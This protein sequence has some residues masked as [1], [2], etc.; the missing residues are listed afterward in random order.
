VPRKADLKKALW[1][2]AYER[3]NVDVGLACGLPGH[4]QIG[5]GMWAM[6]D[7][8]AE[9]RAQAERFGA[10]IVRGNVTGVDVST[11]PFAVRTA[12][13]SFSTRALV[14]ATGAAEISRRAVGTAVFGGMLAASSIGIF[15]VPMLYVTFQRLREGVKR[16]F[17][18]LRYGR[19]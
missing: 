9:M 12:E 3:Q 15:L 5:K 16:R 6:P 10:E 14:I 19:S 11:Q 2:D 18:G 17:G 13:S 7:L 1:L 4:A 8:M